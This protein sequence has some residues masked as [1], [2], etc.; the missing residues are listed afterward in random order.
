[1]MPA[2]TDQA[3]AAGFIKLK[4]CACALLPVKAA[5]ALNSSF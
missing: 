1:M 4:H 5:S 2:L 3:D